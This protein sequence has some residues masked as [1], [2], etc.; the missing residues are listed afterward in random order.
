[1]LSQQS[2]RSVLMVSPA[3][4]AFDTQTAAS[5]TF[6]VKLAV[7]SSVITSRAMQ[8]FRGAV[9]TLRRAGVNVVAHQG[10]P[11]DKRPNAVFPNN[12]ISTWPDGRVFTYPMA[13]ASRRVERD[14]RIIDQ[15]AGKFAINRVID[16]SGSELDERYLE[17]TGVIIFDHIQK[18]AYACVSQRCD[19]ELFKR[20]VMSLGYEPIAFHAY[21]PSGTPI[22]HTN[23]MMGIQSTT[24]VICSEAITD[25]TERQK[26]LESL[27][28]NHQVVDISF[29]QM[30]S[31]CGNV[32]ELENRY[33]DKLLAMS[34][35]AYNGFSKQ[36]RQI[37]GTDKK[38]V[39]INIPTIEAIGGGSVRCMLAEIFLHPVL[40]S[41][42]IRS[43]TRR[44]KVAV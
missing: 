18:I 9:S 3:S 16:L 33:G 36:Q 5:N 39:P 29:E 22:Y 40:Q 14:D 1:M 28:R 12:W 38:L 43:G 17:S 44:N 10:D 20:H 41:P 30:N 31:F 25:V 24:A 21:D 7:R 23:V 15:L 8:E 32:L 35:T 19:T 6:Q 13:T 11:G 26:V 2:A 4:F 37:L 27:A 42:K 34:Q